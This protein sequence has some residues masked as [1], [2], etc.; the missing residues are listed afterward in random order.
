MEPKKKNFYVNLGKG[1][2]NYLVDYIN[3]NYDEITFEYLDNKLNETVITHEELDLENVVSY[4]SDYDKFIKHYGNVPRNTLM[5]NLSSLE[6]PDVKARIKN[7][8]LSD[9]LGK[10]HAVYRDLFFKG[11]ESFIF[12]M[13]KRGRVPWAYLYHPEFGE[14]LGDYKMG[15]FKKYLPRI[16]ELI[17]EWFFYIEGAG[18]YPGTS[19]NHPDD[20]EVNN[21]EFKFIID[22]YAG[23]YSDNKENLSHVINELI[24]PE[25]LDTFIE[26]KN[27]IYLDPENMKEVIDIYSEFLRLLI[28]SS[29]TIDY[30]TPLKKELMGELG[31]ME[32]KSDL[33]LNHN[34][35]V[36][37]DG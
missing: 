1:G 30:E 28:F 12:E 36:M 4:L 31:V 24:H 37:Y 19:Y 33:V 21:L 8:L 26:A 7:L 20:Y 6:N 13:K 23:R 15:D 5:P 18:N 9:L 10:V 3:T 27:L 35:S 22:E 32:I 2:V 34:R 16:K 25:Y 11:L 14:Y 17:N 29:Q